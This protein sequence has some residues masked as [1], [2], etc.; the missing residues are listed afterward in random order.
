[1]FGNLAKTAK[2]KMMQRMGEASKSPSNGLAAV[3]A[4]TDKKSKP[5]SIRVT[6]HIEKRHMDGKEKVVASVS[7]DLHYFTAMKEPPK[8]EFT[9]AEDLKTHLSGLIDGAIKGLD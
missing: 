9:S 6:V 2:S 3:Q 7:D 1:M 5:T 8:T 4:P